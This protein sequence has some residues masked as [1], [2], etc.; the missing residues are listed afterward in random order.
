MDPTQALKD[1]LDQIA[2]QDMDEAAETF[3]N[4]SGWISR[5][6]F[7][8]DMKE[9]CSR[10]TETEEIE[11]DTYKV[12]RFYQ[13][14][15]VESEIIMTGISLERAQEYCS[16]RETSS[17]SCVENEQCDRTEIYGSWFEGYEKE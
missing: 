7:G 5:G 1:L 4:L 15:G 10:F 17:S 2:A 11:E 8:P 9:A 14:S 12:V 3:E 16:N 6:G 13:R